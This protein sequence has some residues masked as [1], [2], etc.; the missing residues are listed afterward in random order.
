M[1][2]KAVQSDYLFGDSAFHY[3]LLRQVRETCRDFV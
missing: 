3:E 1:S 2:N